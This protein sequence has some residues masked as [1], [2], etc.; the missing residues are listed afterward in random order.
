V[1]PYENDTHLPDLKT[2]VERLRQAVEAEEREEMGERFHLGL[3][4][5]EFD[6]AVQNGM[7]DPEHEYLRRF[8]LKEHEIT[9]ENEE[10]K[11]VIEADFGSLE[12]DL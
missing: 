4:N 9:W 1:H 3:F 12:Q 10:D 2:L 6:Y 8:P 11:A 7:I 5:Q